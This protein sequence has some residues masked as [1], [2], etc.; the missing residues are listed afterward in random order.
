MHLFSTSFRK[1][2]IYFHIPQPYYIEIP[3]TTNE[4]RTYQYFLS[5]VFYIF[6]RIT[7]KFQELY[8]VL[9]ELVT[10]LKAKVKEW[11]REFMLNY[12]ELEASPDLDRIAPW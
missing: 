7:D 12:A 3:Y 4:G 8:N 10:N 6:Q 1:K 9:K 2:Y 11:Q 5:P